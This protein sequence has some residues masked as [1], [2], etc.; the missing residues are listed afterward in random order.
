VLGNHRHRVA[1][2]LCQQQRA[3]EAAHAGP[4]VG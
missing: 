2:L 3:G 4:V 1:L